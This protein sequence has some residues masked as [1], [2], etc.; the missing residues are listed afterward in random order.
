M[1]FNLFFIFKIRVSTLRFSFTEIAPNP[2]LLNKKK[3][4]GINLEKLLKTINERIE[5]LIDKDHKIGHSYFLN[6]KTIED[7]KQTFKNKVIPLL[8][9]YFFGDYGKI[10][11]VLGSDFIKLQDQDTKVSFAKNFTEKYED[12]ES[13][14]EK[15]VYIFTDEESWSADSFISIYKA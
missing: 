5:L 9:E 6:I 2:Q 4:E 12:A 10:G 11:L 14:R 1:F 13:L 7:L 8:E 3:I 15:A